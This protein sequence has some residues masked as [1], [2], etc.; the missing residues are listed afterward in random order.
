MNAPLQQPPNEC[1]CHKCGGACTHKPGWFSPEEIAPLAAALG[2]TE[3]QLFDQHLQVDWW[4]NDEGG[5]TFVLS[6]AVVG[7]DVGDMFDRDPRGT[8]AWLKDGNCAIHAL[9][10]PFECSRYVHTDSDEAVAA[11]HEAVA[12]AWAAPEQQ[13]KVAQLLGREPESGGDWGMF[14]MLGLGGSW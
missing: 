12:T 11:R 1:D 9:G 8:C 5:D 10:K 3:Q 14:D 13:A 2:L 7:G 4:N 6:P